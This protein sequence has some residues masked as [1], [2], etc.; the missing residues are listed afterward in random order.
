MGAGTAGSAGLLGSAGVEAAGVEEGWL[1]YICPQIYF[2]ISHSTSPFKP[3]A[4][5]WNALC[6]KGNVDLYIGI[7]AYRCEDTSAYKGGKEIPA[8]LDYLEN[9]TSVD[10]VVFFRYDSLMKNY[11]DVGDQ[12]KDR[13]YIKPISTELKL[14]RTSE[15]LDS[16]YKSTYII[17]ISDPNFPLCRRRSRGT[18]HGQ[19]FCSLCVPD[20]EQDRSDLYP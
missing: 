1:D 20:P 4:D 12:I 19:L 16:S 14:D 13:F 6:A 7:G 17:G 11:A 9:L 5:W 3:I 8:Q 15:T 18:Y 2:Q 10:G